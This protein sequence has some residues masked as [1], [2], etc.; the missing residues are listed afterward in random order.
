MIAPSP[1]WKHSIET[2]WDLE[3]TRAIHRFHRFRERIR[4]PRQAIG[5]VLAVGFI[6]LYL[7]VGLTILARRD[8]VAPERLQLWLSGGMVVYTI[9][10]GLKYLFASPPDGRLSGDPATAAFGLWI[11]GGP[12]PR[13]VVSLHDVVRL[14]PATAMKTSLLCVVLYRDV[15]SL[16]CLWIGVFAALFTLE[17]IR[18]MVSQV[19]DALN[20]RERLVVRFAGVLVALALTAQWALETWNSTPVGSDP[21]QYMASGIGVVA[22]F[23]M[24]GPVQILAFP[25]QA[26]SHLA[27]SRPFA[28]AA[29]VIPASWLPVHCAILFLVASASLGSLLWSYAA[30]DQW[31]L[32]R[33]HA[34]EQSMLRKLT[35]R[36]RRSRTSSASVQRAHFME[37]R[38][39]QAHPISALVLRQWHCLVRY[40]FNVLVSFAIPMA[41]SL[42]PL[43]TGDPDFAEQATKQWIFV[44]GGIA[45]STLLLAPPALQIDFRRDLKRMWLLKSFPISSLSCCIGMLAVPVLVTSLFQWI[46]LAA[47]YAIAAPP[48]GQVVWLAAA[49]PAL[50]LMTFATENALFLA[51]P[52]HIHDQGIAMVIRAKVTFLWKGLVL[53][54]FPV[55]LYLGSLA[56]VAVFPP[57]VSA[58]VIPVGSVVGFWILA[59]LT[60]LACDRCWSR[61]NPVDDIPNEA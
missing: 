10:H 55:L 47:A 5:I 35:S 41:V 54:L 11:G 16:V 4:S 28:W 42:S 60:L 51:F 7:L 39:V 12:I 58:V 22:D 25:L 33:R 46:T 13:Q 14:I 6:I 29:A 32:D 27:V 17:W 45:L 38:G 61:F 34:N 24:S 49:L 53:A 23:A 52:H 20:S 19:I 40:R 30:L 3:T 36:P 44:V 31:S 26:A 15:P 9:Y 57:S 59:G 37:R 18:R 56:C 43:F 50:A 8:T 2:L 21:G 48:I 1:N